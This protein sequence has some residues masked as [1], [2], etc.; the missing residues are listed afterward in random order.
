[1]R[2]CKMMGRVIDLSS[3]RS[4]DPTIFQCFWELRC[5]SQKESA[6][7]LGLQRHCIINLVWHHCVFTRW[8][9]LDLN[10]GLVFTK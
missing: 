7:A 1:V 8:M 5:W 9:G 2:G 6:S 4:T 10:A 3:S